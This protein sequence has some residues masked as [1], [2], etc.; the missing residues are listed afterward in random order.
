M[1]TPQKQK[2]SKA[3]RDVVAYLQEAGYKYAERRIAGDTND[4]GDIAGVNGVCFEVKNQARMDLAGWV[5]ELL[6][7]IVNAK[8]DT[9]AVVHKRKGKT[10]VGD[11]YATMPVSIWIE[12]IK[13]AGY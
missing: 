11:W 2:G 4:R 3:E 9:G 5:G 10:N 7:E 13:K 6:V 8:A 12:L 1:S